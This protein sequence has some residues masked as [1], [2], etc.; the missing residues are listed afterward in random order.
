[1]KNN[2][3]TQIIA[4]EGWKY[5]LLLFV[6]FLISLVFDLFSWVFLVLLFFT[7]YMFRNPERLP[8]EDDDMAVL[9]PCDG[10]ITSISKASYNDGKEYIKVEIQKT[11]LEASMLRAPT[12]MNIKKTTRRYGLMLSS[13]SFLRDKLGERATITCSSRYS[14]LFININAG[15][16]ARKIELFKT[17]GPLKS[18]QRFGILVDGNIELYLALDTRIKVSVGD[19]VKAG[20]SVLGYF[21]HKGDLNDKQ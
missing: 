10:N 7:A 18:A 13:N 15:I 5:L 19:Y 16:F 14:E 1:M 21:A 11:L 4:K 20:E 8:A 17:V 9:S 3:T 2:T 12:L 6:A